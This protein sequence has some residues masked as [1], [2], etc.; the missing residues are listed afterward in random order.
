MIRKHQ[1]FTL[2]ELLIVVAIISIMTGAI[3]L[4]ILPDDSPHEKEARR[5]TLILEQTSL[6]AVSQFKQIGVVF[7]EGG[8][9]FA[10]LNEETQ[11]WS[12][13]TS[14]RNKAFNKREFP[15][16][17]TIE[18]EVDGISKT[19]MGDSDIEELEIISDEELEKVD[20]GTEDEEEE[21]IPQIY[22]LSSG[23]ASKFSIY[24]MLEEEERYYIIEGEITGA[25]TFRG[26]DDE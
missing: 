17:V 24:L 13:Y 4:S 7:T 9:S 18:V 19:I 25:I 20:T 21:V 8:Y 3:V 16:D 1:G 22:F 23:E 15:E 2:I 5:L 12:S 10:A 11:T 14:P 26:S 6:E